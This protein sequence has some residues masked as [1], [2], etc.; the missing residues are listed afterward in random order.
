[1]CVQTADPAPSLQPP[2]GSGVSWDTVPEASLPAKR[3]GW[4]EALPGANPDGPGWLAGEVAAD[5]D[6]LLGG[7]VILQQGGQEG[8]QGR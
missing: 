7:K 6:G 8:G 1:M 5:G 2:S 4:K 3:W